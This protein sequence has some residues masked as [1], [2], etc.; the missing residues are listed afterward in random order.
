MSATAALAAG[1]RAELARLWRSPID[2]LLLTLV[3]AVLLGLMA[4]MISPGSTRDASVVVVDRDGGPLARAIRRTIEK[5]PLL[6]VVSVTPDIGAALSA[7]R[8]ERALAVLV[9]PRGV[10]TIQAKPIEVLYEAQFLAA[11]SIAQSVIQAGVAATL[12]QEAPRLAGA[13][14]IT[15]LPV[16]IPGVRVTLLGNQTV[17]LGWYLG[18]LI[19]PAVIHLLFAV[20]AIGAVAPLM[21]DKS[22]VGFA[23]T[24]TRPALDLLGRLGPHVLACWLW[25][26]IW[27]VGLTLGGDFRFLGS[28]W[29]VAG[30]LLLLSLTTVA[31]ALLLIA[32]TREA[33]T[34]LS[35]AVII[36]GS[37]LAYSGASLPIAGAPWY[38]RA[39]SAVLPLTH[40]VRLEMDVVIGAHFRPI[41]LEA[42]ILALYPLLL[43]GAGMLLVT[44]RRRP[45]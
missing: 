38:A 27:M 37:A 20:S 26:L 45:A 8:S 25:G 12:A 30:A 1:W 43:G 36:T 15:A 9:I 34:A 7:V 21:V 32:A 28:I 22:F 33:A 14:G 6:K 5:S 29:A 19:G 11:G 17:S 13:A 44:R 2:C 3:P 16:T 31:V 10:G 39:W 41:L 40:Y 42:I 18:L 24:R 23:A 35:A 4:A